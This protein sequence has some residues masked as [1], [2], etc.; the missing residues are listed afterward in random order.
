M[1]ESHPPPGPVRRL[2]AEEQRRALAK[3]DALRDRLLFQPGTEA[4]QEELDLIRMRARIGFLTFE[5][6]PRL[7]ALFDRHRIR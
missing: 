1:S 5:D 7:A 2:S 4:L 3:L 6:V